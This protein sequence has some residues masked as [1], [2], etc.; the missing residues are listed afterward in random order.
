MRT[1][2]VAGPVVLIRDRV[3]KKID[4][5][6]PVGPLK[7]HLRARAGDAQPGGVQVGAAPQRDCRKLFCR[8]RRRE[9][10]VQP[11][12]WFEGGSLL[13]RYVEEHGE[14]FL[15]I[16]KSL[17]RLAEAVACPFQHQREVIDGVG[18]VLTRFGRAFEVVEKLF[19]PADG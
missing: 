8:R 7:I 17:L 6:E 5:V 4:V 9:G 15:G 18:R 3:I 12:P 14:S 1:Q 13:D 11:S 16:C 2:R 19:L 10:V